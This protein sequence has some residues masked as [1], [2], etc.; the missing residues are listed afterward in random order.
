MKKRALV[1]GLIAAILL[2]GCKSAKQTE[3]VQ[4]NEAITS[5]E[6]TPAEEETF[7]SKEI[8]NST[9]AVKLPEPSEPKEENNEEEEEPMVETESMQFAKKLKFGWNLGNTFDATAARGLSAETSWGQ[10]KTTKELIHYIKECGFTTIRIPVSWG[11]H[12]SGSD[13]KIEADWMDRVNEVVDW[14]LDEDLYVIINSHHDCDYYYPSNEKID[15]SLVYLECIWKQIAERFKDY[16]ERLIFE[17]MNEPR[18]MNT[19]QEWWFNVNSDAAGI[20][21]MECINKLNQ[22]FVDVVRQSGGNNATRYLMVPP[23]AANVDFARN[24]HFVFPEDSAAHTMLSIHQYT[25]YDFAGNANGYSEWST[26]HLKELSFFAGTY[27]KFSAMGVGVV[28]GEFGAT[29]KDNDESRI[30]WAKDFTE[31]ASKYGMSCIVWDNQEVKVGAENFG[32]VDRRNLEIF[33]PDLLDA[34]MTFYK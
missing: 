10:P 16:D 32:I 8:Q 33:F 28:I 1:I 13:Y 12:T 23:Y 17:S 20:E 19:P 31:R 34:Y 25:P 7:I 26:S 2:S 21:S 18:L 11:I 29:N 5:V 15:G 22:K 30:Q 3:T 27:D 6:E 4:E 14:A 24:T 9:Y